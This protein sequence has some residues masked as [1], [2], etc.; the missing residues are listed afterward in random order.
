MQQLAWM[1]SHFSAWSHREFILLSIL[2]VLA[3]VAT[4]R[5]A[6]LAGWQQRLQ[7]LD[8]A[9]LDALP[10]AGRYGWETVIVLER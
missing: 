9:L 10:W 2:P 1:G 7:R 6:A 5:P 4:H 8:R 3:A